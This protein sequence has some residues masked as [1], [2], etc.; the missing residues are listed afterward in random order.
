MTEQ[1]P[2]E[3][4][5]KYDD[6]ELRYYPDY[7]LAQ[8]VGTGDFLDVS[9]SAFNPLFQFIAGNNQ[10]RQKISMTAPVLQEEVSKDTHKVSFVMPHEMD[11]QTTP[12]PSSSSVTTTKV[13]GHKAA[14]MKFR[15]S[16][17]EKHMKEKSQELI[18]SVT[19]SG[20]TPVGNV[21]YAR[22]NPPWTPTF[23]RHNEVLVAVK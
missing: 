21:Y 3:L 7:V 14:V 5:K 22:F 16:W 4:L 15:G 10:S 17:S 6:F 19:R 2:F 8:V 13:D 18:E 12:L 1:Q 20:L 23:L 11:A 9:Y